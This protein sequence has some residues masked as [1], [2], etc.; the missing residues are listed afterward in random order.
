[1]ICYH[2][3]F[4][5]FEYP[6]GD[7]SARI[8]KGVAFMCSAYIMRAGFHSSIAVYARVHRHHCLCTDRAPSLP[9]Y[10]VSSVTWPVSSNQVTVL[11]F[12]YGRISTGIV[13][14]LRIGFHCL[15]GCFP[16]T[17]YNR[18]VA[19]NLHFHIVA[20]RE[21]AD[22]TYDFALLVW[23]H[24]YSDARQTSARASSA[25]FLF[26]LT[27][28]DKLSFDFCACCAT[29]SVN[30]IMHST[31]LNLLPATGGSKHFKNLLIFQH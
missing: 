16:G 13:V 8:C 5:I 31:Y 29:D 10:A 22:K 30:P 15:C 24:K 4:T 28:R 27:I 12:V 6:G 19:L 25:S 2:T 23:L 9:V 20:F 21:K 3:P 26:A 17:S 11:L 18:Q 14:R 7:V 1:M